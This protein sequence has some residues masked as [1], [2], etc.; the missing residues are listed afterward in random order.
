M[1]GQFNVTLEAG[2][3]TWRLLVLRRY[4]AA[5][6]N[7]ADE[8]IQTRMAATL[9]KR[10][11]MNAWK[12]LHDVVVVEIY[13]ATRIQCAWRQKQSR[14]AMLRKLRLWRLQEYK[15]REKLLEVKRR[16]EEGRAR[17]KRFIYG[18]V[19]EYKKK[20]Q[21][22]MFQR[23]V[24]Q[25]QAYEKELAIQDL[26]KKEATLKRYAGGLWVSNQLLRW[27]RTRM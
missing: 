18:W 17:L 26:K 5:I 21:Q 14:R 7:H 2:K 10:H 4:F 20:K 11:V 9:R 19:E 15:R 25:R 13:Y 22:E 8:R 23:L 27:F 24:L 12:R 1:P 3:A 16:A 6:R